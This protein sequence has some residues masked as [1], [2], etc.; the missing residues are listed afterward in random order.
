MSTGTSKPPPGWTCKNYWTQRTQLVWRSAWWTTLSHSEW[1]SRTTT[2]RKSSSFVV[3]IKITP[4]LVNKR[5]FGIH[6][7]STVHIVYGSD[8]RA[9]QFLWISMPFKGI[10]PYIRVIPMCHDRRSYLSKFSCAGQICHHYYGYGVISLCWSHMSICY[11]W[12]H[13]WSLCTT[14]QF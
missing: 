13:F 3:N 11:V 2:K 9:R 6:S 1:L 10:R 5:F 12:V 7:S 14:Y 8:T 4:C